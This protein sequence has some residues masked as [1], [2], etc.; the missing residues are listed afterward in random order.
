MPVDWPVPSGAFHGMFVA[1]MEVPDA[2]QFADQPWVNDCP[3]GS[4]NR[5]VQVVQG[6]PVLV[7]V[8]LAVYPPVVGLSVQ[9]AGVYVTL[10]DV[11]A[12]AGRTGTTAAAATA[13]VPADIRAS[14]RREKRLKLSLMPVFSY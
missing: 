6:S 13:S 10:H 3:L 12:N 11:A 8:M 1:V 14:L 7:M 9:G 2:V 4:V 5:R